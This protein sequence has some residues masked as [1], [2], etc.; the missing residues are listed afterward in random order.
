MIRLL[1]SSMI[2]LNFTIATIAQ[3]TVGLLSFDFSQ[4]YDG[5]NLMFPHNQSTVFLLNNCGEIVHTWEDEPDFRPGNVVELLPNGNLVKTK[6]S[7]SITSD[8]IWA[9]GG[10][11]FVE[12]RTWDN[13]LLWTFERNDSLERLHHDIAIMPNGNIMMIIWEQKSAEEAFQAGRDTALL[14]Q[15]KLWPDYILEVEPIG[16]DSFNVAWKWHIWDHLVQDFDVDKDNFGVVADHPELVDINYQINEGKAD[17]LHTNSIDYN[18]ELDH[19]MIS[20]PFLSEVWIIDHST[21]TEEAAGHTGG[22]SGMGGD[23]IY[24]WGN[25]QVF[26]QGTADDQTLFGAHDA[27][28]IGA[29]LSGSEP[30]AGKIAVFN[31]NLGNGTYSAAQ[32]F[33]PIFDMY[34][35]QYE[36]NGKV[37]FPD[38]FDW[39]YVHPDTVPMYSS[40]L[41]G[42]QIL[43]NG[44]T[45][46]G[47]GRKGYAFEINLDEEIIWEYRTPLAGGFPATQGDTLTINQNITFRFNRIPMDYPAFDGKD[48]SPKGFIELE[49]NTEFC[50][51][52]SSSEELENITTT[53][54]YPNPVSQQLTIEWMSGGQGVIDVFDVQGRLTYRENGYG[55]RAYIDVSQWYTGLYFVRVNGKSVGKVF[56]N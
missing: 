30:N 19:V 17:W 43:P 27:H 48:L 35:S 53:Y 3:N 45:L 23:L 56:V 39:T 47:V 28:W 22:F 24:R 16:E 55:G 18:E 51:I 7:A 34:T 42:I 40:G 29:Y 11:A 33:D 54:M 2:L 46:I 49:P 10:G 31:N 21:T 41:S 9:G 25:D 12:I 37:F 13:D 5:Y 36:K 8:P 26:D 15:G 38:G 52:T 44:N 20:V 6:R 14:S 50:D 32:I 4:H 1:L